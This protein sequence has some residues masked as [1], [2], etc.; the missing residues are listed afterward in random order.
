MEH[1]FDKIRFW[2]YHTYLYLHDAIAGR[3]WLNATYLFFAKYG[4]VIIMLSSV[5]L[6]LKKRIL[7]F[8]S[9]FVALSFAVAISLIINIFWRRPRPFISH[10]G[11]VMMPIV[12]G[13][14]ASTVSFPSA[15]TYFAFTVATSIFLCGH[16]RLGT[17][18][19][20]V[21]V[22]VA[23]GRIGAGLHYPSDTVAGALIGILSGYI[24]YKFIE[25]SQAKWRCEENGGC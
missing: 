5:Y 8:I 15:H 13:L 10:S 25:R 11:T 21:A 12:Q 2:D 23:I 24:A 7:A 16:R 3:P 6:I 20:F 19:Y 17:F 4:I 14:Y 22:L 9:S 1:L 18:L